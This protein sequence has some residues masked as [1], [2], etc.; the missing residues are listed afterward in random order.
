MAAITE[1]NPQIFRLLEI[2]QRQAR[3]AIASGDAGNITQQPLPYWPGNLGAVEYA[4]SVKED[5][6]KIGRTT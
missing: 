2:T 1:N 5:L 6:T 3:E 4:R